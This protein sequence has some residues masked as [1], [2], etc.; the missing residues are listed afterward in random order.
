MALAAIAISGAC[1]LLLVA[2]LTRLTL[3]AIRRLVLPGRR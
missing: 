2:P 1:A 3:A